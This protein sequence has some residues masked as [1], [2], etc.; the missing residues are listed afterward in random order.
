MV[1]NK[2]GMF[3]NG[4]FIIDQRLLSVRNTYIVKDKLGQQ[5]GFIKQEFVSLGPKFWFEDNTGAHLGEVDGKVVTVHNEYEI[6]D[7]SGQVKARI[8]KKILKLF[9]S[10]WWMEDADGHEIAKI[11]GNIVRHTYDIVAHDKKEI[12]KVHRNWVTVQD[13]Y[14]VEMANPDF[15]PMFVL[16]FAVAMD[17]VEHEQRSPMSRSVNVIGKLLGH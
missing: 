3:E 13:E 4:E 5:L 17:N 1:Q 14:C 2:V 15:N 9:G 10:E 6:K 7:Q 11:E 12:A 8:K 16:A